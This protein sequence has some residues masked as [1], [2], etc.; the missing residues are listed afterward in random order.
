MYNLIILLSIVQEKQDKILYLISPLWAGNDSISDIFG[1][2]KA[3]RL[4]VLPKYRYFFH[5]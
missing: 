3:I 4:I 1:N 2:N 5:E